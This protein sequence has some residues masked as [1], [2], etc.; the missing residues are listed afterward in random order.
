M[1]STPAILTQLLERKHRSSLGE[2]Q[3]KPPEKGLVHGKSS[4]VAPAKFGTPK[5]RISK[6]I[7]LESEKG[8]ELGGSRFNL[9][10]QLGFNHKHL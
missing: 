3:R 5:K 1:L 2:A 9:D 8:V 7:W 10:L 4:P 6:P